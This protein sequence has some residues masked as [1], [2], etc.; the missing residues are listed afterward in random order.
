MEFRPFGTSERSVAV[1][2]QGTWYLD[3]ASNAVDA[4]RYGIDLGM[5]HIDTAEMY[6]SGAAEEVVGR[7]IADR[8]DEV[9]LVSK[10]LP[11]N[12]SRRGTV[13]ACER[14][15]QRLGTDYL[16]VY[17]LHW[18]GD[19]PLAETVEAFESLKA[20]GKI[21]SYG[22]SNFDVDGLEELRSL[23]DP[24]HI[25]CNQ[26]LYNPMERT[27]ENEVLPWCREHGV[28]IVAYSPFGHGPLPDGRSEVGEA[29]DEVA[30]VHGVSRHQVALRFVTRHPDVFAIPKAADRTHL[31]DNASAWDFQLG[32]EAVRKLES[33]LPRTPPGSYLPML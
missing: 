31:R 10:V 23:V 27:V 7:A 16:D 30:E 4:L 11:S 5:T 33:A 24:S 13:A 8:R 22:V 3:D 15:L 20:R 28:P 2:G 26:V 17:L 29:L 6:G 1:I 32:D 25:A 9:F 18:P 21:R 19:H 14:S 12:A